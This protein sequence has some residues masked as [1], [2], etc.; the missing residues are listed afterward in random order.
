ME[1]LDKSTISRASQRPALVAYVPISVFIAETFV[2]LFLFWALGFWAISLLPMHLWFV[3]KTADDFHWVTATWVN[4]VH[5]SFIRNK[6]LYGAKVI[7]F[8]ASAPRGREKT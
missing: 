6:G 1:A 8:T 3:I 5:T 2:G 7:T 4:F